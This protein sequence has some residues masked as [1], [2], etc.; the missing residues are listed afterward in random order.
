MVRSSPASVFSIA[1]TLLFFGVSTFSLA[2]QEP[3]A[4]G[5]AADQ[6]PSVTEQLEQ[7]ISAAARG[8]TLQALAILDEVIEEHPDLAEAYF[9]RGQIL[10]GLASPRSR[11]FQRR[12]QAD[13]ALSEAV[14][15]DPQNPRYLLEL[16]RLKLLQQIQVDARRL[17]ERA[18]DRAEESDAATLADVHYQLALFNATRWRYLKDRHFMPSG[19]MQIGE[20]DR[21]RARDVWD[22]LERSR[23]EVGSHGESE[24]RQMLRHLRS[25]LAADPGHAGA[26]TQLLAYYHDRGQIQEYRSTARRFAD[27]APDDPFAYL[28]MGLG[29]YT[30]GD[31]DAAAGAFRYALSLMSPG[32]RSAFQNIGHLLT[33]EAEESYLA[34]EAGHRGEYERRFWSQSDPLLITG[35]NEFWLEYMARMAYVDFRFGIPERRMRGWDTERGSIHL[36][37][38]PPVR[39]ATY[40]P[41]ARVGDPSGW[42]AITEVWT[43]GKEGPVFVFQRNPGY[44]RARLAPD[45]AW[46][47]EEYRE[48]RPAAV[49]SDLVPEIVD[50]PLQ[51]AR[52][53]GAGGGVDLG[54]Y[55]AL[56]GAVTA[57]AAAAADVA[58]ADVAE[59]DVA[60][61]E[62]RDS[63]AEAGETGDRLDNQVGVFV[64]DERGRQIRRDV[65]D[66]AV[67]GA[68]DG[69]DERPLAASEVESWELGVPAGENYTVR[70][71]AL[72]AASA[73]GSGGDRL[74]EGR[75]AVGRVNIGP[76]SFPS[77]E[78]ALSD[79]LMADALERQTPTPE[80]RSDYR[81]RANPAMAFA[82]G[83]P[84]HLYFEIYDLVPDAEGYAAYEVEVSVVLE[85]IE[86]EGAALR[87]LLGE[88]AD[89]WGFSREGADQAEIRFT[90]EERVRARDLVPEDFRLEIPDPPPG[91]YDLTVTVRDRNSDRQ[92]EARRTFHVVEN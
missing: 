60:E 75:A 58:E 74:N 79:I 10:A 18:L 53:R 72:V 64:Q 30:E 84:V 55:A 77:G 52:F 3:T 20:A 67:P 85:E 81:I 87:L 17:F 5:E 83:D 2:A 44:R 73:P 49:H 8:D 57:V 82:P 51:V 62:A 6:S 25:A 88:L 76:R 47:A 66:R 45:F 70:V 38:G 71:E 34:F 56:P 26:A 63:A 23:R 28:A 24:R 46:F 9:R 1:A 22:F 37:Y 41:S 89:R 40:S 33:E 69:D 92:T 19:R 27:A 11:E 90:R 31:A 29:S 12:Q 14:R 21:Y 54:I 48:Q 65:R 15:R 80:G 13:D 32:E 4:A 36:R 42:G 43:Y 16:G 59:A 7:G 78:L 39:R 61:A 50:L 86:R 91:R 68:G 35:A